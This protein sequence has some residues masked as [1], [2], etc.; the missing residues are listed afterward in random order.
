MSITGVFVPLSAIT[1]PN[2]PFNVSDESLSVTNS[3][4]PGTF[5]VALPGIYRIV[6]NASQTGSILTGITFSIYVNGS[7]QG[8]LNTFNGMYPPS[9]ENIS[10]TGLVSVPANAVIEVQMFG[11]AGVCN[12][13]L[14]SF[15][16]IR[17]AGP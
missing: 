12:L 2:I 1:S 13:Q 15:Y 3:L 8:E 6:F 10:I 17:V 14:G 11:T 7:I 4:N 9:I 16:I 5:T